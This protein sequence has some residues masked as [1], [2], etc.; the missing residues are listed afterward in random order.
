[1]ADRAHDK[2]GHCVAH[3][4]HHS[5]E[6]GIQVNLPVHDLDKNAVIQSKDREKR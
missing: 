5:D 2:H 6:D 4:T 1:M 3:E